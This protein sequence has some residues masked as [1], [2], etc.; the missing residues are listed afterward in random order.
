LAARHDVQH[1]FEYRQCIRS[2]AYPGG[3]EWNIAIPFLVA[4]GRDLSACRQSS[5]LHSGLMSDIFLSYSH[6][7]RERVRP[8]VALLEAQGWAI[9]WDRTLLP[10]QHW[11]DQLREE[12]KNCR[13][14]VVVWTRNS[15]T[16]KWVQLEA[17]EGL[18]IDGLVPIQLDQFEAAPIPNDFK[19]IHAADLTTWTEA[20]IIRSLPG[21]CGRY[22]KSFRDRPLLQA[23]P[24]VRI[25]RI[26]CRWAAISEAPTQKT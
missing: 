17:S 12:L 23:W 20:R 5:I 10:G 21:H 14:V 1:T 6:Q 13:A 19:H 4:A 8:V 18:K 9:W 16:S 15:V 24:T 2:D 7:D 3:A 11:E 25:C 22:G 26:P